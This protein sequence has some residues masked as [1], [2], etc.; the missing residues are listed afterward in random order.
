[1]SRVYS[2]K[3]LHLLQI[4]ILLFHVNKLLLNSDVVFACLVSF[5]RLFQSLAPVYIKEFIPYLVVLR[6]GRC[7]VSLPLVALVVCF[8]SN[9][10]TKKGGQSLCIIL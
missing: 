7:T 2:F 3:C 6:L 1:M 8:N 10:S 5:L 9:I 4:Q